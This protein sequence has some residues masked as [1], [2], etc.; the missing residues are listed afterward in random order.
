[1]SW[2]VWGGGFFNFLKILPPFVKGD[3]GGEEE[4]DVR[5][6]YLVGGGGRALPCLFFFLMGASLPVRCPD[7]PNWSLR[8]L[9]WHQPQSML[10]LSSFPLPVRLLYANLGNKDLLSVFLTSDS[11]IGSYSNK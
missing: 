4:T 11:V 2:T 9:N 8:P 6:W 5:W 1:M 10:A 3:G 7:F